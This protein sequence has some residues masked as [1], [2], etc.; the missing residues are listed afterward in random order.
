MST[1]KH[2]IETAF[3]LSHDAQEKI[4]ASVVAVIFLLVIRWVIRKIIASRIKDLHLRY[5]WKKFTGYTL[6]II[7]FLIVGRIWFEGVQSI[8]TFLG[9]LS[10]G[11]AIAL[12]DVLMNFAGW[13]FLLW[14]KPFE[15]GD[16]IQIGQ[17]AG[18]VIDIRIFQFTIMEIGNWVDA[19]QSTG[20]IIHIPNGKIFSEPQG[21][22]TKG[23]KYIW[24]EIQVNLTFESNWKK[25]KELLLNIG[26]KQTGHLK[27]LAEEKLKDASEK[28]LIYYQKLSPAVYVTITEKGT[29]LILR[30]LCEPRQ[31]RVVEN[32][33]WQDVL[34]AYT[35]HKDI[36]FAYPTQ[37]FYNRK[38]EKS[39][40]ET[41]LPEI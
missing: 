7:G 8:A 37:R 3:G 26:E 16:R 40:E 9:L 28:F 11:I 33:I 4:I 5:K 30:F 34:N 19:D 17:F 2:Y 32:E 1:I 29:R 20:R 31:R 23:F 27:T 25:A 41:F 22:Y 6:A 15:V 21:N 14:R 35:Q 36:E 13:G 18:D 10:A 24:D 12:K 39:D 38:N